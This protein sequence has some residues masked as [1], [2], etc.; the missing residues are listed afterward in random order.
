MSL[1]LSLGVRFIGDWMF[2]TLIHRW[3]LPYWGKKS[4]KD[5]PGCHCRLHICRIGWHHAACLCAWWSL[6]FHQ[7]PV[8]IAI[9][10][11]RSTA[12]TGSFFVDRARA[13]VA[14]ITTEPVIDG[15]EPLLRDAPLPP[16][17]MRRLRRRLCVTQS[18]PPLHRWWGRPCWGPDSP[19]A[20]PQHSNL[21]VGKAISKENLYYQLG[22]LPHTHHSFSE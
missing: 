8:S 15:I 16:I 6:M 12:G 19:A 22:G 13:C 4:Y 3:F 7:P 1:S 18:H 11:P 20:H 5:V 9:V 14:V 2:D 17:F 10:P 21:S